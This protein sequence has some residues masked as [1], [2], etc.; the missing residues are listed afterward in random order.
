MVGILKRFTLGTLYYNTYKKKHLILQ[1]FKYTT[2]VRLLDIVSYTS[3]QALGLLCERVRDNET[4]KSKS[5]GGRRFNTK[6]CSD[7]HHMDESALKSFDKMS[8]EINRLVDESLD[9]SNPSLKLAALSALEVLANRFPANYS[10][11]SRSLASVAKGI[12]SHHLAICS[13]CLR[14]TGVLV[15]VLG[16]RSVAELPHIMDCVIKISGK[17]SPC[18]DLKTKGCGNNIPVAVSTSKES[19]ALSILFALEAIVDKLGGFLNPYLG[20]I[21]EILVLFPEYVSGSDQKLNLK[22]D[23]VRKLLTEKIPV[24]PPLKNLLVVFVLES[25]YVDV[26]F[27]LKLDLLLQVR[28][29]LPPLLSIY[30][31]AVQSGDSSLAITFQML[32]N[33]V[34]AMDRS[35]VY[36]YYTNIF[37]VCLLALD[38]RC[39]HPIS[40]QKIDV[41]EISVINAMTALTMKLTETMFKPLFIRSIEWADSDMEETSSTGSTNV[42]RAIAFYSLVS[43]LAESHR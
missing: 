30:S 19:L 36:S 31:S 5:K 12:S 38:L 17:G 22:A 3:M 4:V 42:D 7:W 10:I 8:L 41:V 40:V 34:H 23:V 16:P 25:Q 32:A 24:S 27:V 11:F 37:D 35:S 15:N 9:N 39:Q 14:A 28:L 21:M 26:V 29:V 6:P 43:K 18:S 1:P 33:L 20:N 2:F 13:G